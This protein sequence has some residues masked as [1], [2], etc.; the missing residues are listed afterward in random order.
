MPSFMSLPSVEG[1][2]E[3]AGVKGARLVLEENEPVVQYL[4]EWKVSAL[5]MAEQS[6]ARGPACSTAAV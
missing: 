2:I 5:A 3:V 4:V 1:Y 6:S